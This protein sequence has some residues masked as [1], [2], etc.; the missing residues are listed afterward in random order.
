MDMFV[1]GATTDAS[2][3][4][5]LERMLTQRGLDG[6]AAVQAA[7][8]LPTG[9]FVMV[10]AGMPA[11]TFVPPPRAIRHVRHRTKYLDQ[12]VAS[13]HRFFFRAAGGDVIGSAG[14]LHEFV[15]CLATLPPATIAHHAARGDFSRW[16]RD[17]FQDDVLADRAAKLERRWCRGEV[18]DLVG[19]VG[20][21]IRRAYASPAPSA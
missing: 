8:E 17:V 21:L 10:R 4:A 3:A 12:G 2:E 6:R 16:I 14:T 18:A 9:S 11:A 20:G 19:E 1:L 15:Q 7:R 5:F 13:H